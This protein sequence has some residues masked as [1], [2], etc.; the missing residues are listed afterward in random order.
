MVGEITKEVL[1]SHEKLKTKKI[2]IMLYKKVLNIRGVLIFQLTNHCLY[3]CSFRRLKF[4]NNNDH[5]IFWLGSTLKRGQK[6]V[7]HRCNCL[8]YHHLKQQH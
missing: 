6:K 5:S 2:I 7:A 3:F 1:Y 4:R 8:F